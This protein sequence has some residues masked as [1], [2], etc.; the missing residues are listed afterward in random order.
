MD[1]LYVAL[2]AVALSVVAVLLWR[3][4][5]RRPPAR[6]RLPYTKRASLLTPAEQRFYRVLLQAV[7]RG[8]TAF[9]K[10][11]LLDVVSVPD[12]AWRVYGAP[13]SGMHLDFVLADAGTADVRLVIELD[14]KS[15]QRPEVRERDRFKDGALASAGVPI[16]R[17]KV[18]WYDAA[19]LGA[20]IGAALG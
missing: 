16:L 19:E 20:R 8:M 15:H 13:A 18:G 6:P 11:R 12:K 3:V 7:P 9:V 17:V 5:G 4:L 1:P 10:V 14:D 2:V